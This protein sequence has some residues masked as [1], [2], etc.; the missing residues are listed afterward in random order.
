MT[1]N[2]AG[3]L[4]GFVPAD[5]EQFAGRL[6]PQLAENLHDLA[7]VRRVMLR[8]E[9]SDVPRLLGR[10]EETL[11]GT[12]AGLVVR[13]QRE[14]FPESLRETQQLINS[15]D[16]ASCLIASSICSDV[17]IPSSD[18]WMSRPSSQ[19]YSPFIRSWTTRYSFSS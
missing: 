16:Y 6:Q 12:P 13:E 7:R 9:I 15:H 19:L 17:G 18:G 5:L 1:W 2:R 11:R 14:R 10:R 3:P 4:C 8:L